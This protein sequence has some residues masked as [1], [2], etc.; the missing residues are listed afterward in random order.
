[1]EKRSESKMKT[2]FFEIDVSGEDILSKDYTICIANK[3]GIIKGFKFNEK[4]IK[5]LSSRYGQGFYRYKKS[6]KEKALFKVRV[7]C[8]AIYYIFKS[9]KIKG[10]LSLNICRDFDGKENDIKEN[11]R[12]LLDNRLGLRLDNQIIFTKL[13]KESTA[14]KYAFLMR[15]DKKNKLSTYIKIT[16]PDFEEFLKK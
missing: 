13:D 5:D 1:M 10:D 9:I 2:E 4:L 12:F 3:D 6:Q 8:I 14:N 16:L 15:K 7:Y 11:L